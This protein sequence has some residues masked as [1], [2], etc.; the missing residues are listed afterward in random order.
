M[1]ESVKVRTLTKRWKRQGYGVGRQQ[2]RGQALVATKDSRDR[3]LCP[4]NGS[5]A[6]KCLGAKWNSSDKDES[7]ASLG[8]G[9]VHR[10]VDGGESSL[11][12]LE[13]WS[14]K[15]MHI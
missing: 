13:R 4:G 3:A 5:R 14:M 9:K 12:S 7:R 2:C 6:L 1:G 15:V 8:E 11:D 10:G